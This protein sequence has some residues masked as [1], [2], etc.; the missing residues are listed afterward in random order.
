MGCAKCTFLMRS[1]TS[2]ILDRSNVTAAETQSSTKSLHEEYKALKGI[3][4]GLSNK[5]VASK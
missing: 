1:T 4:N 5:E 2:F 3:E